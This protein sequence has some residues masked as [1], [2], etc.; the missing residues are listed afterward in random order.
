[1]SEGNMSES[2]LTGWQRDISLA[3]LPLAAVVATLALGQ[4]ATFPNLPWYATLIKPSF[5]PPNW[6]FGPVW[7]GLYGLM[8]F[9]AF[10]ILR[11]APSPARRIALILFFS[12]LALNA[13]W[14]WAF[15]AAH[16]PLLGLIDIVPQF[17]C[18]LATLVVFTRLDRLAGLCLAP[19]L[20]WVGY[21]VALN[22][23]IYGLNG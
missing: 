8:A 17:F 19:L 5:N 20:L 3:A 13:A 9:A 23:A 12:Q 10:R 4:W 15:F 2:K 14:S 1:M 22:I 21:A 16:S 18:I 7:T 11:L 6:I